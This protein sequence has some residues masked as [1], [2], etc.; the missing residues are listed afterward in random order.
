[1]YWYTRGIVKEEVLQ[2][3]TQTLEATVQHM[4][5]MLYDVEHVARNMRWNVEH[6][7]DQ[8]DLMFTYSKKVLELNPNISGCAIAFEPYY[9]RDRGQYFMSYYYRK[10]AGGSDGE[11]TVVQSDFF[12]HSPYSEQV[13]YYMPVKTNNRYWTDP[14]EDNDRNGERIATYC[15]PVHDKGGRAVGVL[16]VD[17]T[18]NRLSQLAKEAKL[19]PN[20]Y[21]VILGT[22]G[23]YIV[24][25]D[26][27]KL[28]LYKNIFN[29]MTQ[30]D[31]D[32]TV[33][34]VAR[35]MVSGKRGCERVTLSD[36]STTAECYVFF[37]PF[38]TRGWSAC[39]ICPVD[40]L[41]GSYHYLAKYVWIIGF[42]SIFL[43]MVLSL[44]FTHLYL[45]PLR[46]LK[47]WAKR[48][49]DG[50]LDEPIPNSG[51]SDEIGQL[52]EGFRQMQESLTLRFAELQALTE[53]LKQQGEALRKAYEQAKEADRMKTAFLH[54]MTDQM[55]A[56]IETIIADVAIL[57]QV[58]WQ[59]A[60]EETDRLVSELILEGQAI[61]SLL[62]DLIAL[63]EKDSENKQQ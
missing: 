50:Q 40:D 13:W 21:C 45:H 61:T 42:V 46:K 34:K 3:A 16:A 9:Y 28:K 27:T 44:L 17:M 8:P 57:R 48:V 63:S 24:H 36:G 41:L 33:K 38:Q 6:H 15:L 12:G 22:N 35:D 20:S 1:M 60:P 26:S 31:A 55:I 10:P 25:R 39:I 51:R 18:L 30:E 58:T 43:L 32:S 54:N 4:D 2:K 29:Q 56:P 53:S 52:Q 49:A 59:M 19:S 62:N 5:N 47:R 11:T 14:L 23:D 7:L 37:M